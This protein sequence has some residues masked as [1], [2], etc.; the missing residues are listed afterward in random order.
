MS[1]LNISRKL[2]GLISFT[3]TTRNDLTAEQAAAMTSREGMPIPVFG[4]AEGESMDGE[5]EFYWYC[6]KQQKEPK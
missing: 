2:P 6:E 5:R 3:L 1:A 4:F